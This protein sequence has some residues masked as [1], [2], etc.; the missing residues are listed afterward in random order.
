MKQKKHQ[1]GVKASGFKKPN[2]NNNTCYK[3]I[4][5]YKITGFFLN[6]KKRTRL[7]HSVQTMELDISPA[8]L[9]DQQESH[10]PSVHIFT[11]GWDTVSRAF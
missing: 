1:W 7:N 10:E 5:L 2:Q 9:W 6:E 4:C 3:L 8:T 11:E